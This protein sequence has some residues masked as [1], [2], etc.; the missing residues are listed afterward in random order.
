MLKMTTKSATGLF[1]TKRSPSSSSASALPPTV[2]ASRFVSPRCEKKWPLRSQKSPWV[3]LK[4]K[5][6]GNWVLAKYSATPHLKPTR[7][8]SEMKSTTTP[9]F[10]NQERN[11]STATSNAVQAASAAKRAGS[12]PENSPSDVPMS[13]DMAEVQVIANGRELEDSHNDSP[14]NM[15][16]YS[17]ASGGNPASE[18]SP[19][20]AGSRYAA[21]VIPAERSARSQSRW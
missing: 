10:T 3:P 6:F 13:S 1:L 12:P 20:P 4:P 2:R 11:A 15:Q 21:S 17:P 16:G 8:V 14:E 19:I 9:A 7:T 5:S 18:A